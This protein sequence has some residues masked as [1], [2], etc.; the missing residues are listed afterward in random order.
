[1]IIGEPGG[2]RH[3]ATAMTAACRGRTGTRHPRDRGSRHAPA[4]A[5]TR[6]R[7]GWSRRPARRTSRTG[8]QTRV[9]RPTTPR[10]SVPTVL[11]EAAPVPPTDRRLRTGA[12]HAGRTSASA[13]FVCPAQRAPAHS[14]VG[15][16]GAPTTGRGPLF[17]PPC[18][19]R[20]RTPSRRRGRRTRTR[21]RPVRPRY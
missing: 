21:S 3:R 1:M 8:R 12:F 15:N 7:R 5:P 4:A 10:P 16:V 20:S 19:S 2:P 14:G 17:S 9:C 18:G 13:H 11:L 6:S